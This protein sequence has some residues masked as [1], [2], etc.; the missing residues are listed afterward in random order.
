MLS[1]PDKS[2]FTL[3]ELIVSIAIIG[4]MMIGLQQV[5]GSALTTYDVTKTKQDL[6]A[7][8]R[9]AMGRM[10]LFVQETNSIINPVPESTEELLKVAEQKFDTYVNIATQPEITYIISSKLVS[11]VD[12]SG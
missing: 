2:G 9:F 5:L 8:A 6:M 11:S 12:R 3:L 10:V 7:S 4:I 1:N